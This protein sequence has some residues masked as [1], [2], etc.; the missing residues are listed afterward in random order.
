MPRRQNHESSED[1]RTRRYSSGQREP[2]RESGMQD[3]LL[4]GP[5]M[6]EDEF[7]EM[8]GDGVYAGTDLTEASLD[9]LQDF[10]DELDIEDYEDMDR[11]ELLREIR[12]RM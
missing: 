10:A 1:A 11:A 12:S 8:D 9:E 2:A 3:D 5:D 4:D 6:M 7:D